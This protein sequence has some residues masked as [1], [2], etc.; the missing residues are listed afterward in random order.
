MNWLIFRI[1]NN[2]FFLL[3]LRNFVGIFS[4]LTIIG[5]HKISR[6]ILYQNVNFDS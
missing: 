2:G 5:P 3:H 4:L 1:L 6:E